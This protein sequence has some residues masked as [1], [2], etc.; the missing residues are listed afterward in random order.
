MR[1]FLFNR[2]EILTVG[3]TVTTDTPWR[4]FPPEIIPPR[5][6]HSHWR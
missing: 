3:S 6:N 1:Q 5:E 2:Y 4:Y